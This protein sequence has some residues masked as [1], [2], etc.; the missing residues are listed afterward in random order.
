MG[1]AIAK[2]PYTGFALDQDTGGAIRAPGRC[3]VYMGIGD[4]AGQM[5]GQVYEEGTL[6]Y[7][8]LKPGVR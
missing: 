6:Y 5:A 7:L 2:A 8:F 1:G 4:Q 3:D